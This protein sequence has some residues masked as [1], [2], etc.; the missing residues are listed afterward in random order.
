MNNEF[1][2][3]INFPFDFVKIK[4]EVFG[5]IDRIGFKSNQIICQTLK[6]N[7]TD[8][9]TGVG[10]IDLL[11]DKIEQHFIHLN[12]E[13]AGTEL[14]NLIKFYDGFR[15]R[16]MLMPPRQCYSIHADPAPRLHLPI[17]TSTQCWMI[18]PHS[19]KCYRLS[20]GKLYLADTTKSH[21]F[22]NGSEQD[23]IHVIFGVKK[24]GS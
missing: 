1:V 23:R 2:K 12:P 5:I 21:T 18:W 19:N 9:H 3:I 13:L 15:A 4:N 24:I 11:E 7:S 6:E 17:V 20:I 10:R 8:W 22:I 14:G 16:I